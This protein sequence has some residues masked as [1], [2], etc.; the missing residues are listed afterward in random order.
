M[1]NPSNFWGS[2]QSRA[3]L[4]VWDGADALRSCI[5]GDFED[6]ALLVFLIF[7]CYEEVSDLDLARG[8]C[9]RCGCRADEYPGGE[10]GD[11]FYRYGLYAPFS[12]AGGADNY[13]GGRDYA[14]V[15]RQ[16]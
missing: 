14:G 5:C 2:L 6:Y 10:C 15:S 16:W 12:I 4:Q 11:E 13:S 3:S 7:D 9:R 8:S 1:F